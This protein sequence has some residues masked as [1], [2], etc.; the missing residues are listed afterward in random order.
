MSCDRFEERLSAHLDHELPSDGAGEV[1]AH[2][3][4]CTVCTA[5]LDGFRRLQTFCHTIHASAGPAETPAVTAAEW[6]L[7]WESVAAEAVNPVPLG[8]AAFRGRR[9]FLGMAA[10]AAAAILIAWTVYFATR[11]AGPGSGS[12]GGPPMTALKPATGMGEALAPEARPTGIGAGPAPSPGAAA[13]PAGSGATAFEGSWAWSAVSSSCCVQYVHP[14][15]GWIPT[16]VYPANE[17][18]AVVIW[19]NRDI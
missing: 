10:A 13:S 14:G 3:R 17:E 8:L 12:E 6:R 18:D 19:L 11:F 2:L 16:V 5:R 9:A 15:A 7:R 4:S 1:D